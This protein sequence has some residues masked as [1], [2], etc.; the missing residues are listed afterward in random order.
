MELVFGADRHYLPYAAAAIRSC[1]DVHQP[2]CVR[3]HLL[4]DST[5][6][7]VDERGLA[8]MVSLAESELVVH[9]LDASVVDEL[10]KSTTFRPIVSIRLLLPQLLA[11]VDRAIYLDADTVALS[12]LHQLWTTDLGGAP[13][14][15]V[16]N[17]VEPEREEHVRALGLDPLQIFNS[18][19]LLLDLNA[20]RHADVIERVVEAAKRYAGQLFWPDQDVLNVAFETNWCRLHPRWNVQNSFFSLRPIA[21][22]TIPPVEVAEAVGNPSIRHFEGPSLCKPW[23][24]L[25]DEPH[26]SQFLGAMRRTPWAS[27][28]LEDTTVVTRWIRRLPPSKRLGAYRRVIRWRS[29]PRLGRI[30]GRFQS[31]APER[32]R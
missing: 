29:S 28:P 15:A 31:V 9:R 32:T 27:E 10:P 8:T 13:L 1:L 26:A 2:G 17:V 25:C 23:H 19:V 5:V 12:E 20:M 18:G 24:F 3:I 16:R 11:D 14:G 21:E 7:P 22:R 6:T 4:C 30:R